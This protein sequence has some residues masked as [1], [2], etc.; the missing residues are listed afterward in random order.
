MRKI[1]NKMTDRDLLWL[2]ATVLIV[3][4]IH[5]LPAVVGVDAFVEYGAPI[6]AIALFF[7]AGI[8]LIFLVIDTFF[9]FLA[10]RFL[11]DIGGKEK[12]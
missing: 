1:I 12:P 3:A 2:T 8:P 10:K 6:A 9:I 11:K 7:I 5:V 4:V